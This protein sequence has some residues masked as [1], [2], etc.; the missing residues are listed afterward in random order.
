[1]V[2][3]PFFIQYWI[4][5]D[6]VWKPIKGP[7]YFANLPFHLQMLSVK[8]NHWQDGVATGTSTRQDSNLGLVS[9][10][11]CI[12]MLSAG[13]CYDL[14]WLTCQWHT[15]LITLNIWPRH[16]IKPFASSASINNSKYLSIT[17]WLLAAALAYDNN[18]AC[19]SDTSGCLG[20]KESH[21][22][23][24]NL[25]IRFTCTQNLLYSNSTNLAPSS[26]VR[27]FFEPLFTL[28]ATFTDTFS[29]KVDWE[30]PYSGAAFLT[31]IVPVTTASYTFSMLTLLYPL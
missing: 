24:C 14:W 4:H 8:D 13:M 26:S 22:P 31:L 17:R 23:F 18:S 9:W 7:R 3:E 2:C 16:C 5:P 6:T 30:T 25:Y 29:G 10:S 27:W 21:H 20:W 19:R 28:R 15:H 11:D 12:L 1:M